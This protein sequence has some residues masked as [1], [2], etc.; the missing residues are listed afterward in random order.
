MRRKIEELLRTRETERKEIN[1]NL[2]T[3]IEKRDRNKEIRRK[4]EHS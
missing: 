4:N 3:E 2:K 1:E